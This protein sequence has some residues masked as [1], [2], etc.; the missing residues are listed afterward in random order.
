VSSEGRALNG[1]TEG[2]PVR[3]RM[4]SGQVISGTARNGG[5]VEVD[6]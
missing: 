6:F 2:E 1:A 3:V 4:P 5:V